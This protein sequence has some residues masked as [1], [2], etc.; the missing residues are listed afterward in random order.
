MSQLNFK[1]VLLG[2]G[3]AMMNHINHSLYHFYDCVSKKPVAEQCKMFLFTG[4]VGKTSILL[5]YI[6][7]TYTDGRASTIQASFL[8]KI[9]TVADN[10]IK[11]SSSQTLISTTSSPTSGHTSSAASTES[12]LKK[13]QQT[14]VK[15]SIWDTAGQERFHSLGPIY[16]RDASGAVLVYDITDASSFDRV[17]LWVK[18]L[19]K[20]VG[21]ADKLP[22]II[23]GNKC[24]LESQR[25]VSE[26]EVLEYVKKVE[27][28]HLLVSAKMAVNIDKLFMELTKRMM[29]QRIKRIGDE[30]AVNAL[31]GVVG[32]KQKLIILPPGE[33][34]QTENNSSCC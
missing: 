24:D 33:I 14:Q 18:E 9:L 5:R 2:E 29:V 17:Q 7:D 22:I 13:S 15:L 6:E 25:Q 19:R 27:A 28:F 21:E 31:G 10:T 11:A 32:K 4:R 3:K 26:S 34:P 8:T 20:M 1:V 23:V 30:Q 16:Y 12:S